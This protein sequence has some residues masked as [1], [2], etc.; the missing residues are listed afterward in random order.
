[1]DFDRVTLITFPVIFTGYYR[2][3]TMKPRGFAH[4]DQRKVRQLVL[5]YRIQSP[6]TVKKKFRH[7]RPQ[8]CRMSLTKLSLG[9]NDLIIPAPRESLVSDIP[10]GDGNVANLFLQCSLQFSSRRTLRKRTRAG[11]FKIYGDRNRVGIGLSYRL[12]RLHSLAE[13]V[14]WNRFMGSLKV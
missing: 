7:S 14:P 5:V 1:M 6:F 2:F 3:E 12:A 13:L 9:G 4:W 8:P 11:I 10:A